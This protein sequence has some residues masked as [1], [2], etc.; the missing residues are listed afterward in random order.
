MIVFIEH[1]HPKSAVHTCIHAE[2]GCLQLQ[3]GRAEGSAALARGSGDVAIAFY[4]DK[5]DLWRSS[6]R[7]TLWPC[8]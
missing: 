6:K 8:A 5:P 4:G 1:A 3:W 7:L 2:V